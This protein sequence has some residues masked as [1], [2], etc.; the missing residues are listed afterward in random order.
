M[1]QDWIFFWNNGRA[2]KLSCITQELSEI[3]IYVDE[4]EVETFI[5]QIRTGSDKNR[6]AIRVT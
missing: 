5:I 6:V 1:N 4:S 3:G 2:W